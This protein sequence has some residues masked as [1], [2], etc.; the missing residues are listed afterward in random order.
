MA[1]FQAFLIQPTLW[2]STGSNVHMMTR[3]FT[4]G[5]HRIYRSYMRCKGCTWPAELG[6]VLLACNLMVCCGAQ[7]GFNQ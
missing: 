5:G 7:I 3:S 6:R 1:A 2:K 4:D